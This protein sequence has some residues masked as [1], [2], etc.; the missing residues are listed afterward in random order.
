MGPSAL[1]QAGNTFLI[2]S[3][4]VKYSQPPSST[5]NRHLKFSYIPLLPSMHS[6]SRFTIGVSR[7]NASLRI[8][9]YMLYNFFLTWIVN[10]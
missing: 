10:Y 9:C 3:N 6:S 1:I 4:L 7:I 2:A 5:V 8:S